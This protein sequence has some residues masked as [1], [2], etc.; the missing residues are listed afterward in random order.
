M[1]EHLSLTSPASR[2]RRKT[3][4]REVLRPWI[5]ILGLLGAALA[6]HGQESASSGIVGQIVDATLAGIPGAT[7]TVT[8][9]G[10]SAQ[11]TAMAD[12]QGNFS[13]PNLPPATYHIRAEK[14]GF[15]TAVLD[16]F[17]LRIGDIA[18]PTISLAVGA[19]TETVSVQ[20][21]TPLLQ[22][23]SGT[24]GQVID[25]KQ[26]ND[27]PLNGRNLVQLASLAA[28]VSPRQNL[29]RGTT[30]YGARNEYVQVE[31]G[32]DGSTNYVIDGVYVRSLRFNNL[33]LQPSIDTVQ[34][35]SV[36]R[37][38]F[39][40][41]YG[42]GQAA[43]SVVTKS[44]TNGLRGSLYE[45]FRN[46]K[47]DARNFFAA[48]KPAYRR[49]QFGGTLGGPVIKN[50]FFVF[51]GYEGLRTT[52]GQPF[53]GSVPNPVLLTGNLSS[54]TTPIIDPLTGQQFTGNTIPAVR[55]SNFAKVLT[56][57]IPAPNNNAANNFR[58]VKSFLDNTDT[59]TFRSDQVLNAKHNLFERYIWYDGSQISPATFSAINFPQS[60]QNLAVGETWT[61]TPTI[62]NEVRLGYNRANHIDK[63]ISLDGQ[64][65]VQ[66]IGLHN[67]AGAT[68]P[69][70]LGRPNWTISGFSG[71]GEGTITQGALEN[72]Y[73]ISDAV[74]KIW[75][76]HTI[77]FGIQAQNRRFFHITEVPPRG[78]FTFN[79]QFSGNAIADYLL[80]YC[81]SCQGAFGSSR[82]NYRSNTIS[83]FFDDVWQVS[84]R[85]TLHLGIR[86]EYL[87][88]WREQSHQEGAF[89]PVS[90]KIA[91][92]KLPSV[93]P[94]SLAPLMINQSNFYPE[95]ILNPDKNNWGPRIGIAYRATERTVVRTGF[96]VYFDNLNLN[97]LQFTRLVPPFYGNYTLQPDR[98]SPLL[99]D[100][101]FPDLN[102]IAQFPAP[103]SVDPSNRTPYTLQWNFNIQHSLSRNLLLEA[104][105]TGSGSH[106][107]AKRYNQNQLSFG[108]T[109]A[110][111]RTPYPQFAP[112]ILTSDNDGNSSFNALS[113]RLEK[114]YSAGLFFGANYQ[115]SKNIDNNSGE[116]EA[117]D[118]AFRTNKKLDRAV[119][120]YHQAHRAAFSSGY[121]LPFGKGRHWL[122]GDGPATY[123]LGGW[124]VQG[125]VA[126]LSGFYVTPSSTN[127]CNC[128]SFVPQRVHAVRSDYGRLDH[129][130]PTLWYDKAAFAPAS[131]GFQ[132]TAGRNKIQGAPFRNFDFSVA[133]NFALT[134]RAKLQYRAEF[135]NILNHPN[136]GFPD[137]N[138]SNVTAGV[139]SSAY[140]GRSIQ[141]GLRAQW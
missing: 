115:F 82:S 78:T 48:Q 64:N 8:N 27:L 65:W 126:L 7:V 33:S 39:S 38:S 26:I 40:T 70:N 2:G 5:L 120:R 95:G 80:G 69:I 128:G 123:A 92:N 112:G 30:Q 74:S 104:A 16:S 75:G 62:V 111:T 42:Q 114:R 99:V 98:T 113:L 91:Y 116:V 46:D 117:N 135:F 106:K 136:F 71:Q 55:I 12:A 11:R 130:T 131:A 59:V 53:L 87:A 102:N 29:Q 140:D 88:P 36:L 119:S 44:G 107:L 67:L 68:D 83:P 20:A 61:V 58:I 14:Q 103:F 9:T 51:G 134:E 25:Q 125:I 19:V 10:T 127:V 121:E 122:S 105:Y 93:I 73:S 24:V 90:G 139:I 109:P 141:M 52:Q 32:R 133:K 56:P 137:G 84:N 81:S 96:G 6:L 94:A 22:T 77:R 66:T 54:V 49:N 101:L 129:P 60:G 85:L 43:I 57:T 118:T 86:Y 89:D 13:I 138:I 3:N 108:T 45:Y 63:P 72:I 1:T 97:E 15:Q 100:N 34:E 79:G 23:A 18:H 124:Q 76:K 35:F 47:L 31:G 28:G 37:N 50:K 17:V 4:G 110:I 41:E 21:E 132:G